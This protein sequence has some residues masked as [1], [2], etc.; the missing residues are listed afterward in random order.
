MENVNT[1]QP[2]LQRKLILDESKIEKVNY[3]KSLKDDSYSYHSVLVN[4]Y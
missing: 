3:Y 1:S 4:G 2:I